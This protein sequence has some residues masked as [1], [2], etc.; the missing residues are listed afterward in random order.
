M[1]AARRVAGEKNEKEHQKLAVF[2]SHEPPESPPGFG[3]RQCSAAF[4]A[5]FVLWKAAEH[6]RSPRR[7]R[8]EGSPAWFMAPTHVN[9]LEVFAAHELPLTPS[10]SP[11]G[12]EGGPAVA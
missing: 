7:C 3:L 5:A 6:C 1:R 4:A 9:I 8:A 10:L 2:P 12:G 11:S